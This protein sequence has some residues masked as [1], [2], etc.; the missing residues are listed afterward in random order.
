MRKEPFFLFLCVFL[1]V[2]FSLVFFLPK[3]EKKNG[4]ES[5][6]V[7]LELW[8]VDTFEGGTG[9]RSS[10]LN[11]VAREFEKVSGE[12]IV[13]TVKNQSEESVAELI[14]KGIVPDMLSYGVG[15]ELP[16]SLLRKCGE[17]PYEYSPVWCEGGYVAIYRKNEKINEIVIAEQKYAVAG[18]ALGLCEKSL[19]EIVASGAEK[20]ETIKIES[21]KAIYE[22]YK[23][24]GA[25]LVG[26]Q[27][28]I[29]R[30][31]RKNMDVEYV[32]LGGYND[33]FQYVSVVSATDE[34]AKESVKFLAYL[35]SEKVQK[36]L[37]K[38]GM[39]SHAYGAGGNA[40]EPIC[41][42]KSYSYRYA[43]T[44]LIKKDDLAEL[45]K[46]AANGASMDELVAKGY[47]F[48]V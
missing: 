10:F 28:D 45:K 13:V 12:K 38:I 48:K 22:F 5:S 31:E 2:C 33:L 16:Y 7:Y 18:L 1:T 29:Y 40:D 26:T 42:L 3:Y 47:V 4:P 41:I 43:T 39:L 20:T 27:R 11:A 35:L 44:P 17:P 6:R 34:K 21:S 15:L 19:S 46:M 30:L 32:P 23:S 25:L 24:K 8:H 37:A 14:G 9:S 36:K